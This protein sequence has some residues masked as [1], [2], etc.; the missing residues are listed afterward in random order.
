MFNNVVQCLQLNEKFIQKERICSVLNLSN[1]QHYVDSHRR[2]TE[3][4]RSISYGYDEY[5]DV[6][7]QYD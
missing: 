7:R 6:R 2:V 1:C 4:S 3:G 5:D